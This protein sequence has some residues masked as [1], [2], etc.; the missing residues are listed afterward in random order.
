MRMGY[1]RSSNVGWLKM[2]FW[3]SGRNITGLKEV[4][5]K[6]N[7]N[8][9]VH[10]AHTSPQNKLKQKLLKCYCSSSNYSFCHKRHLCREI[11]SRHFN[12]ASTAN[13]LLFVLI[14]FWIIAPLS[15]LCFNGFR[16]FFFTLFLALKKSLGLWFFVTRSKLR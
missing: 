13:C 7:G 2:V 11:I 15:S 3:L 4:M 16:K 10:I 9:I 12:E 14:I 8:L 1:Q 6:D 5:N